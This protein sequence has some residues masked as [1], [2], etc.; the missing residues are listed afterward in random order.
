MA[1]AVVVVAAGAYLAYGLAHGT[2]V[3]DAAD[4]AAST[5]AQPLP[6][7]LIVEASAEAQKA[8]GIETVPVPSERVR[9]TSDAYASVIDL[10]PLFDLRNK[11]ASANADLDTARAQINVAQAKYDSNKVL[12]GAKN[13]VS[14]QTLQDSQATLLSD[15]AKLEASKAA[16]SGIEA[17]LRQQFGDALE[18]DAIGPHSDILEHLAGGQASVVLVSLPADVAAPDKLSLDMPTRRRSWRRSSRPHHRTIPS[19]RES[20]SYTSPTMP[21]PSARG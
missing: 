18:N 11:W 20:P 17:M 3:A 16:L 13:A 15:Q 14:E 9:P 8:S 1:F 7:Q 10:Q 5:S 19:F 6:S 12:F 4:P 2:A 21:C